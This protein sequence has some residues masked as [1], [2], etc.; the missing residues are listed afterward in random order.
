[1]APDGIFQYA[2]PVH[3][4]VK[5]RRQSHIRAHFGPLRAIEAGI[6]LSILQMQPIRMSPSR[7]GDF[8]RDSIF[9]VVRQ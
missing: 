6:L 7:K 2:S 4:S 1:M 8:A 5:I 9:K 3:I